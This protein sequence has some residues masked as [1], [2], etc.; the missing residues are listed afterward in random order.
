MLRQIK[1]LLVLLLALLSV[2]VL[3]ATTHRP[4]CIIGKIVDEDGMSMQWV[5]VS[6]WRQENQL[7]RTLTDARGEFRF[8]LPPGDYRLECN[9]IGYQ[10]VDSLSV[11][12]AAGETLWVQSIR[13]SQVGWVDGLVVIGPIGKLIL[14]IKDRSGSPLDS[15]RVSCTST[16]GVE[17]TGIT[18][19]DGMIR[20]NPLTAGDYSLRCERYGYLPLEGRVVHIQP[21]S[22]THMPLYMIRDQGMGWIYG[23]VKDS[24][25]AGLQYVNVSCILGDRRITG[26]QTDADGVFHM[27]APE[28]SLMLRFMLIGYEDKDSIFVDVV[29][30]ETILLSPI[31]LKKNPHVIIMH[32]IPVCEPQGDIY[33]EFQDQ[34][35]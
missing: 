11:V 24:T 17:R 25:G 2:A 35:R 32:T 28:G 29:T 8:S 20:F 23:V 26:T 13:M 19:L 6:C 21:G 33:M 12:V 14:R 30:G 16:S 7:E 3:N 22:T 27:R 31:T 4:G 5:N 15:V 1:V 10:S 9:T 34:L 18:N